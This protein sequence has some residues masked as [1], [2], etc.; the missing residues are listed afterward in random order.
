MVSDLGTMRISL[1]G[2]RATLDGLEAC[3]RT[4][5]E[6]RDHWK[7]EALSRRE[8]KLVCEQ[9]EKENDRLRAAIQAVLADE[10]G[11]WSQ[12]EFLRRA[13]QDEEAA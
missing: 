7:A 6:E 3:Y 5:C 9:L 2:I 8:R 13:L 1:E 12:A 4:V 10:G 11:G